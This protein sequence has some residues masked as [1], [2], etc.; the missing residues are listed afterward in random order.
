MAISDV[1]GNV[2]SQIFGAAK[3]TRAPIQSISFSSPTT[4]GASASLVVATWR[5][6]SEPG[7]VKGVIKGARWCQ[8]SVAGTLGSGIV[9]NVLNITNSSKNCGV[10]TQ[11]ANSLAVGAAHADGVGVLA[12]TTT[13]RS[14]TL[15]TS[16]ATSTTEP[17][18]NFL[19]GDQISFQVVTQA[20]ASATAGA[21]QLD[22]QWLD[23]F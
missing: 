2:Y 3:N 22:Y 12:T 16:P 10:I 11:T 15:G 17:D 23:N 5:V 7:K 4:V 6:P 9:V 21:V 13:D 8:G 14:A 18:V 1:A 20:G 19:P